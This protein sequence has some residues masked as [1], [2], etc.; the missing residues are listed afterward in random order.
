MIELEVIKKYYGTQTAKRSGVP[1]INHIIEGLD[2]LDAI[3]APIEAKQAFCIYPLT[4]NN[5]PR[6]EWPEG[7]EEIEGYVIGYA[8]GY[9][10]YANSYLCRPDTDHYTLLDLIEKFWGMPYM[11]CYMLYADKMQSAK[12]FQIY[13]RG[14]HSRSEQLNRYFNLWL[15]LLITDHLHWL[16]HEALC[17]EFNVDYN[18][19]T[20]KTI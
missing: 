20:L 19:S 17:K 5:I 14:T 4:Q 13:H 10:K 2:I 3:E 6:S 12:D 18:S 9:A 7:G 11:Y 8:N 16:D 1:L 15:E